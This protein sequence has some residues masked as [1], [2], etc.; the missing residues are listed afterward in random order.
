MEKQVDA[1]L[2]STTDLTE[3]KIAQLAKDIPM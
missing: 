3:K 1:H 2:Y